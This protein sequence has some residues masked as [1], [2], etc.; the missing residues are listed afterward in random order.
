[1]PQARAECADCGEVWTGDFETVADDVEAHEQFHD[2]TIQRVATDGGQAVAAT[3][4]SDM[5][6]VTLRVPDGLLEAVDTAVQTDLFPNRSEAIR[7]ALRDRFTPVE[8][9]VPQRLYYAGGTAGKR[10]GLHVN[11]DCRHLQQAKNVQS[12]P[13]SNPPQG[14]L[15]GACASDWTLDQL[16]RQ[17]VTDGGVPAGEVDTTTPPARGEEYQDVLDEALSVFDQSNQVDVAMEEL[18]ECL[19]ELARVQ[20]G[21]ANK[22]DVVRE[23]ADA[24]V[25]LDQMTLIFGPEEVDKA[26]EAKVARLQDRLDRAAEEVP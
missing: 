3:D 24:Q 23:L 11:P 10:R 4:T 17:P 22:N 9:V 2:V 15:C 20:R 21:T 19:A 26:V 14:T 16:R 8:E 7:E 6:R 5:Q 25:M 13:A 12:A 1:M 18:G